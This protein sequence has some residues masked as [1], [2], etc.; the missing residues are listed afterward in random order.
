MEARRRA[1]ILELEAATTDVE[2]EVKLEE[3]EPRKANGDEW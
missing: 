2:P 1:G 3:P